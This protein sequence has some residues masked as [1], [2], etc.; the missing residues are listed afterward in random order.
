MLHTFF[1]QH[2]NQFWRRV[3]APETASF[4]LTAASEQHV[5]HLHVVVDVVAAVVACISLDKQ[6][7]EKYASG[8]WKEKGKSTQGRKICMSL[9][10]LDF[11]FRWRPRA[12]VAVDKEAWQPIYIYVLYM[13][14]RVLVLFA[15]SLRLS[16]LLQSLRLRQ[17]IE[18]QLIGFLCATHLTHFPAQN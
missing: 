7:W 6:I 2:R 13:H 1:Q 5:A 16:R 3:W 18:C 8:R 17:P 12:D 14:L 15:Q 9:L 4:F 11:H 10:P